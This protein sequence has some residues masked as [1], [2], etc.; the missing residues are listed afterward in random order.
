[1][2]R[3]GLAREAVVEPPALIGAQVVL[4]D[5]ALGT[6]RKRLV[7]NCRCHKI[8]NQQPVAMTAEA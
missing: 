1:M 4:L 3:F 8:A 5:M 2:C 7:G 6:A